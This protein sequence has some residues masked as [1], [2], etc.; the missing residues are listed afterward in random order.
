VIGWPRLIAAGLL[1]ALPGCDGEPVQAFNE[2]RIEAVC[3]WHERCDTFASTGFQDA[4]DCRGKLASD[5]RQGGYGETCKDFS[6]SDA[7]GCVAAWD[8]ADCE[9]PPDLTVC[10]QVCAN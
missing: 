7:D 5:S 4:A 8:E 1:S 2:A 6:Q 9:T 10:E 3:S